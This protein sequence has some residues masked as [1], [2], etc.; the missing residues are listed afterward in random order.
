MLKNIILI[1]RL[2]RFFLLGLFCLICILMYVGALKFFPFKYKFE[3]Y[4]IYF[5]ITLITLPFFRNLHN[6]WFKA[7]D[8]DDQQKSYKQKALDMYH[9]DMS[10]HH[11]GGKWSTKGVNVNPYEYTSDYTM[12]YDDMFGWVYDLAKRI[13]ISLIFIV[14]AP[15]FFIIIYIKKHD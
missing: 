8:S 13:F 12:A 11:K 4:Q 1:L 3:Y 2:L 14:F 10:Q 5:F 6:E 15:I 9:Q 7:S